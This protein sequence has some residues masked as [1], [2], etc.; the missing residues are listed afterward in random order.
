M[1]QQINLFNPLFLKRRKHFSAVT[2]AQALGVLI[3]GLAAFY[4]FARY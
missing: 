4:G 3:V 2:M 1:S